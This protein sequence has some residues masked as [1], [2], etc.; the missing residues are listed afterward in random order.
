MNQECRMMGQVIATDYDAMIS[1]ARKSL[2]RSLT[3]TSA[4]EK[5]AML[6]YIAEG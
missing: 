4:D 5:V 6:G 1:K 3:F 2:D